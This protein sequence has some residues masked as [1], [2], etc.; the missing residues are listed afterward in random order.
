MV[1]EQ[2]D[3]NNCIVVLPDIL[4]DLE[5]NNGSQSICHLLTYSSFKPSPLHAE[6]SEKEFALCSTEAKT[7][8]ATGFSSNHCIYSS[9]LLSQT[10][11]K[12]PTPLWPYPT[13]QSTEPQPSTVLMDDP[14]LPPGEAS[15]SCESPDEK[16]T[17]HLCLELQQSCVSAS[18]FHNASHSSVLLFHPKEV[19]RLNMMLSHQSAATTSPDAPSCC[20]KPSFSPFHH[21]IFVDLSYL[22]VQCDPCTSSDI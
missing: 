11:E 21:S 15:E 20:L 19:S 4:Q 18:D 8:S 17:S 9:I 10:P 16:E 6:I 5:E 14:E 2:P 3:I 12:G 22:T 13:H 7:T 1:Q